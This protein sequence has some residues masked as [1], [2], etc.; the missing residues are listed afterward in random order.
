[1]RCDLRFC[2]AALSG[3]NAAASG[4][5][6]AVSHQFVI[7]GE[8]AAAGSFLPVP[9]VYVTSMEAAPL[10]AEERPR[11][12][13]RSQGCVVGGC[14]TTARRRDPATE[15]WYCQACFHDVRP[16]LGAASSDGQ[17]STT[18]SHRIVGKTALSAVSLRGLRASPI[19]A[20]RCYACYSTAADVTELACGMRQSPACGVARLCGDCRTAHE[21]VRC[22][23]CW[24]ING[25]CYKCDGG[26]DFNDKCRLCLTCQ[27]RAGDRQ[28]YFCKRHNNSVSFRSCKAA[29]CDGRQSGALACATCFEEQGDKAVC[30][31]CLWR[32]WQGRCY[33]CRDKWAQ[34]SQSQYCRKCHGHLFPDLAAIAVDVFD[35]LPPGEWYKRW[36]PAWF[37]EKSVGMKIAYAS[38]GKEARLVGSKVYPWE[39]ARALSSAP[40]N[41]RYFVLDTEM[42]LAIADKVPKWGRHLQRLCGK[43]E[44]RVPLGQSLLINIMGC[45][46]QYEGEALTSRWEGGRVPCFRSEECR[47]FTR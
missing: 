9:P 28:C 33:R 3:S 26:R 34:R 44:G 42:C 14:F 20:P 46:F 39:V 21:T 8:R 25:R 11:K 15:R 36:G 2:L 6:A 35:S 37:S 7:I 19:Y 38:N 24:G 17:P 18:P 31:S 29:D 12:K 22:F 41:T 16:D 4:G 23:S 30:R 47:Q 13:S 43:F 45:Q 40:E 27:C 32:D 1:M 10:A 5:A